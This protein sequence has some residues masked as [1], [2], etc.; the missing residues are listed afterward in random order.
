MYE[1]YERHRTDNITDPELRQSHPISTISG[2]DRDHDQ[3]IESSTKKSL[4]S[5]DKEITNTRTNESPLKKSFEASKREQTDDDDVVASENIKCICEESSSQDEV[6]V[7]N[8][9]DTAE[10]PSAQTLDS[11]ESNKP[12]QSISSISQVYNEQLTG[13]SIVCNGDSEH[14]FDV[15]AT[16]SP[17]KQETANGDSTTSGSD[18]LRKTL[19]IDSHDMNEMD[20]KEIVDEIVVEILTKSEHS[21]DNRKRSLDENQQHLAETETTSSPVIKDEE[22]EH[23]VSEVV[24]GA[25]NFERKMKRDSENDP[26]V[27]NIVPNT[28]LSRGQKNAQTT[29]DE[30]TEV[31]NEN[32]NQKT[33]LVLSSAAIEQTKNILNN[34]IRDENIL[35]KITASTGSDEIKEIVTTLVN[36]VIENCVNQTA[37]VNVDICDN[38]MNRMSL[39]DN[40][41]NNS[42]GVSTNDSNDNS[43]IVDRITQT[44]EIISALN[45]PA[46]ATIPIVEETNEEI[47]KGIVDE[48]IEKCVES[49]ASAFIDNDNNNNNNNAEDVMPNKA[50][51]E[52]FIA[53]T[54]N[55]SHNDEQLNSVDSAKCT[56][57][58]E[59]NGDD[60]DTET[61]TNDIRSMKPNRSQGTSISTSTQVE[62]NHFG[63]ST[64]T[65]VHYEHYLFNL[66]EHPHLIS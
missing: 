43:I 61:Q 45:A 51:S 29:S 7:L 53:G 34:D 41:N 40:I 48:I 25:R 49:E 63:N 20:S 11:T 18:A 33:E 31:Q 35:E 4:A 62:N 1:H 47:I 32:Q 38:D 55:E 60:D 6:N 66:L 58:T 17:T 44:T 46:N 15:G 16:S 19:E 5:I 36:D 30:S 23:A 2:W 42:S 56:S 12:I 21:L 39:I 59:N 3:S 9:A 65:I 8:D 54:G 64:C 26:D 14:A 50:E 28:K 57:A 13:Q 24:K 52:T 37:T 27:K 22:I 10:D